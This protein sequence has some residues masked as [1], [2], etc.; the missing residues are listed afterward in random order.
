MVETR[1]DNWGLSLRSAALIAGLGLLTMTLCAPFAFFH[2]LPSVVV[3]GDAAATVERFRSAGTGYVIGAFLL[4]V[5]YVMDVIVAWALYWLLRP[6]QPALSQLAAWMRLLYTAL[7][8]IGLMSTFAAYDLA[9]NM[10]LAETAGIAHIQAAVLSE[11]AT[12][13]SITAVA[14]LFFGVHLLVLALAVWRAPYVP[15]WAAIAVALAGAS[16]VIMHTADYFA[17]GLDLGMLM[18][19]ALGE[20]LFMFW[21]LIAG[22]RLP[23]REPEV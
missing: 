9:T 23:N 5:T 20:L 15:R 19:L 16:Y 14:L 21:L 10:E 2:F 17:P 1:Q 3:E 11:I 7:A 22:W 8:F 6:S 12:A 13:N 18:I 4:F